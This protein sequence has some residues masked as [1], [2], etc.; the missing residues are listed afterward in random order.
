MQM[1]S[2]AL[3]VNAL[4]AEGGGGWAGMPTGS[5]VGHVH[6]QV[7]AI[8]EAE[9]F[10]ASI[11]AALTHRYPGASFFGWNGYHHHIGANIWNSRGA[12]PRSYPSTGLAEVEILGMPEVRNLE[13][14]WRTRFVLRRG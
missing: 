7:G 6:M 2:Y 13:D 12:G 14:P 9:E 4:A 8:P 10:A 5:T 1:G 11:G 3:D